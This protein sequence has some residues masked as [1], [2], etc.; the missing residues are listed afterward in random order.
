MEALS[1]DR[2]RAGLGVDGSR[3]DHPHHL[4]HPDHPEEA[5]EG[6]MNE[7]PKLGQLAPPDA[8]RDAIHIAVAPVEAAET[9]RPGQKV[10]LDAWGRAY[11]GGQTVGIVDPYFD[12]LVRPGERFWLCLLPDSITGLRHVWSH[13]A[14]KAWP[15]ARM[16]AT[17]S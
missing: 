5:L 3:V 6:R 15:P 11:V 2:R 16:E 13:P 14:F 12:G 8:R 4:R 1:H 17:P 7:A 10:G 9:L